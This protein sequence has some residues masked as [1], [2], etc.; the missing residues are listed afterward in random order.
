MKNDE[1]N[2]VKVTNER[3][4]F[5]SFEFGKTQNDEVTSYKDNRNTL[6]DELNDSPVFNAE[7]RTSPKRKREDGEDKLRRTSREEAQSSSSSSTSASSAP[8]T[9]ASSV[10]SVATVAG[11]SV[12]AVATISTLVGINL[13]INAKCNFQYLDV[14]K[15]ELSY[16]LE[17][18]D[19]NNDQFAVYL[20]SPLL[21][22]NESRE[23]TEGI[24]EGTFEGL[25]PDTDYTLTVNDVSSSNYEIYKTTIHTLGDGFSYTVLNTRANFE[26][27]TF[28]VQ[29]NIPMDEDVWY[30]GLQINVTDGDDDSYSFP[31]DMTNYK[32]VVHLGE[33]ERRTTR[34]LGMFDVSDSRGFD[35]FISYYGEEGEVSTATKHYVFSEKD[36]QTVTMTFMPGE[37]EG[38]PYDYEM[39]EGSFLWLSEGDFIPPE[40]QVFDYWMIDGYQYYVED[41][42]DVVEDMTATAC[43]RYD[44]E[45]YAKITFDANGG[46]GEMKPIYLPYNEASL[47]PECGFT[48]PDSNYEFEAWIIGSEEYTLEDEFM[49]ESDT[50]AYAKW[51]GLPVTITFDANGGT[52]EMAPI[53]LHYGDSY[54]LPECEFGE[55]DEHH[56]FGGWLINGTGPVKEWEWK[57]KEDTILTATWKECYRV[58]Y[59]SNNGTEDT[60]VDKVATDV[61]IYYTLEECPFTAPS[62]MEFDCWLNDGNEISAGGWVTIEGDKTINTRWKEESRQFTFKF[63]I[64]YADMYNNCIGYKYTLDDPDGHVSDNFY[65][66]YNN[67]TYNLGLDEGTDVEKMLEVENQSLYSNT[68]IEYEVVTTLNNESDETVLVSGCMSGETQNNGYFSYSIGE[69]AFDNIPANLY[70][71]FT[72]VNNQIYVPITVHIYDYSKS[73]Y[74][75]YLCVEYGIDG[76]GVVDTGSIRAIEGTQWLRIT[77]SSLQAENTFE[78]SYFLMRDR[79]DGNIIGQ[80]NVDRLYFRN[81]T[82]P[83]IF[84]FQMDTDALINTPYSVPVKLF[85]NIE[86]INDIANFQMTINFGIYKDGSKQ[87]I[88][89]TYQ[90]T[91][92]D[93]E[94]IINPSGDSYFYFDFT[95][96]SG[97]SDLF[98][99]LRH[100]V[101]DVTISY[102]SEQTGVA[103]TPVSYQLHSFIL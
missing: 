63:E 53:Q 82:D 28:M 40:G 44:P 57:V 72:T 34:A 98:F 103:E 52:G 51:S 12:V 99:G 48:A 69:Y 76:E 91:D 21:S 65:F 50:V 49:P 38:E 1:Y 60:Y 56:M 54:S 36:T 92:E 5:S 77:L 95:K 25:E 26:Y 74:G 70:L 18:S 85:A 23:L 78:L 22:Y 9:I 29:L 97:F 89:F 66:K 81:T 102:P 75:E 84:G 46:S 64:T 90:P 47:L 24:N 101:I 31:L 14:T 73:L 11:V 61:G 55:P 6:R 96:S 45:L 4:G 43:W 71:P 68:P 39:F 20:K 100:R 19:T 80:V 15:T 17:L 83:Q 2:V 88:S 3:D 32:Q 79:E 58:T 37:A 67:L 42:I 30:E 62:G 35:M 27:N 10:S 7:H 16:V 94:K 13:Y 86:T 41:R 8:S 59:E 93:Y 33:A 87:T